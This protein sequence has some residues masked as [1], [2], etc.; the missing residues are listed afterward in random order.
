MRPRIGEPYAGSSEHPLL[1]PKDAASIM[2]V[3]RSGDIPRVLMGK[4]GKAHVFMPSAYVFP[5]GR[6]DAGDSRIRPAQALH[7]AVLQKLLQRC[8]RGMTPTR[9]QALAVAAIRET[10]E[11]VG[12]TIGAPGAVGKSAA[13]AGF[14]KQDVGPDL[15][16]LRYIARAITPPRQSRRFDT[17]FFACFFDEISANPKD[18]AE[19]TELHD[20]KWV[21]FDEIET[22]KLPVIT[23][24]VLLDL[25][26]E[27]RRD[28][29]LA[30]GQPVPFYLVKGGIFTRDVI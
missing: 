14:A 21:G 29:G 27:M 8:G 20:L 7:P 9:A 4:R 15:S 1:R 3:D 19:S 16:R 24:T 22:F 5:G 6:R 17:R 13:W 26:E 25:A 10:H 28:P 30:Y 23:R 18:V 2:L 11:E 12:L